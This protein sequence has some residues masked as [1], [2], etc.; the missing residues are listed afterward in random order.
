MSDRP[1]RHFIIVG[2]GASGALAAAHLLRG[3]PRGV[4]VTVIEKR[5]Q[6]GR[7]L[8]YA[9]GN[10]NHLLN[11]RAANMS[12][13]ADDPGHFLRWLEV[14]DPAAG[15]GGG[16]GF[17]F[18]PRG[19]YGRYLESLL[20][21]HRGAESRALT[22]IHDAAAALNV[23]PSGVEVTLEAGKPVRGDVAILACGHE[24]IVDEGPIYVGPWAEPVGG[25]AP[26]DSTL[27]ILGSGLTMVDVAIALR[28]HGH[29]GRV[30]AVSRRGLLPQPHRDVE[31]WAIDTQKAP[32]DRDPATVCRWLRS[33]A[34]DC[35]VRGGD[36]RSVI[37]G[38][39]PHTQ[40]IWRMMKPAARRRFLEHGRPWWDVHRH[41]LAPKVASQLRTLIESGQVEIVGGKVVDVAAT[42]VGARVAIRR[43][44]S[45]HVDYLDVARIIS[46]KGVTSNPQKSSNPIVKSIF[47]QGLARLDPLGLGIDVDAHCAI[48]DRD[49]RSSG[50]LF[51]VGPMSQ[52]AFWEIIAVPDI[53]LQAA[54]LA[55]LLCGD[56]ARP[57]DPAGI[58]TYDPP[59]RR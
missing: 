31:P 44:G 13:F 17:Q 3:A 18:L 36:W 12:A 15:G 57:R 10:P 55:R 8:A 58:A 42:R 34:R 29:R 27:L 4:T 49:G 24:S 43:R 40:T 30:V 45:L 22:I 26:L 47:D 6:V 46:C 23:T 7:G 1:P 16:N 39:R 21:S 25:G 51:A 52:A 56:G 14:E 35:E 38:L 28:Q 20:L 5:A 11:V 59:Q 19:L 50:R 53:R 37:D 48:I 41:R 32:F 54:A 33:L 9:T 2:A